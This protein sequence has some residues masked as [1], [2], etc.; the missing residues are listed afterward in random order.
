MLKQS[1][2][3]C[4]QVSEV[5]KFSKQINKHLLEIRCFFFPLLNSRKI[6][7]TKSFCSKVRAATYKA[8]AVR[9]SRLRHPYLRTA[10][11]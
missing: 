1:V 9:S 3:L 2:H 7:I 6:Q 10:P 8:S 5:R 4:I 11:L